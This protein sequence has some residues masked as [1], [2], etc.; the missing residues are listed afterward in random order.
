MTRMAETWWRYLDAHLEARGW[1]AADLSRASGVAESRLSD[2]RKRGSPP[3]I[4]NA[5]A[6]AEAL[7]IPLVPLLV[8]AG[9]LAV[10]EARQ[11]LA[12]YTVD[13]LLDE[14]RARFN[15]AHS[16]VS[17][18]GVIHPTLDDGNRLHLVA[19]NPGVEP[20]RV[21]QERAWIGDAELPDP[22]GPEDGA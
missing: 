19:D 12:G 13:E 16:A 20:L 6:V 14:V 5:R 10:D 17:A 3:A 15:A 2:W 18:G 11:S 7:D 9:V 1:K 22:P 21:Q 4:P 8:A